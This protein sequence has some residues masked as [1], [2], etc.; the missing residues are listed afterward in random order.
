MLRLYAVVGFL[1]H[2]DDFAPLAA[3]LRPHHVTLAPLDP[4]RATRSPVQRTFAGLAR[5]LAHRLAAAAARNGAPIDVLGYSL[6]ARLLLG[7][8][9]A[10]GAATRP[11]DWL[12]RMVLIGAGAPPPHADDRADRRAMDQERARRLRLRGMTRFAQEWLQSPPIAEQLQ[13]EPQLAAALR[14]R[15]CA[16]PAAVAADVLRLAGPA[17]M[18]DLRPALGCVAPPTSLLYGA[19]DAKFAATAAAYRA[20]IGPT[21]QCVAIAGAGHAPHWVAPERTAAAIATWLQ[22]A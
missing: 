2:R 15:R 20:A 19:A 6:G 7:A 21:A 12:G 14:A 22:K 11:P 16:Y 4:V 17:A 13:V 1:G 10:N 9:T 8:V 18:P 5:R 3:A